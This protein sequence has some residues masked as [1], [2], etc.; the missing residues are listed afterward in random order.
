MND[1]SNIVSVRKVPKYKSHDILKAVKEIYKAAGGPDPKGKKVLLK[2]NILADVSPVR[3][4]TTHPEV[5][6]ACAIFFQQKGATVYAGDSPALHASGFRGKVCGIGPVCDELGIE[7]VDFS[8]DPIHRNGFKFAK[9]LDEVDMVISLPKLKTHELAYY[10]GATKNLFGLIPGLS[11]ALLHAKY[12]NRNAFSAMI[13]DVMEAVKPTFAMMDAIIGMEGA[14]PQNGQPKHIGLMLG[15]CNH[16]ALDIVASQIVGYN[17]MDIPMLEHAVNQGVQ[18]SDLKEIEI[19]GGLLKE[20]KVK[21]FKR[22]AIDRRYNLAFMGVRYERMRR[23]F[24]RRPLFDHDICIL[25]KKCVQIC[26]AEALEVKDGKIHIHDPNCIR[27]YCCH[28]VC[29]VNAIEIK[30]KVFG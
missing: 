5:F 9:I 10:T 20:F 19:E 30:R 26:K 23:R 28:E 8:E 15:S 24:D 27:C 7:W 18:V 13:V 22:I 4:V 29:P 11:K 3:A 12:P 2:P 25:C 14:G 21:N 1:I 16:I 17:P 6:K